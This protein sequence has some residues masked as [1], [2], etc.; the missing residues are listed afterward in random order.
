M[1]NDEKTTLVLTNN[2]NNHN[3]KRKWKLTIVIICILGVAV[4]GG[5]FGVKKI[6]SYNFFKQT[7]CYVP[8]YDNHGKLIN[9]SVPCSLA[10]DNVFTS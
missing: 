5:V 3:K 4:V 6:K 2:N 9:A 10:M 1:E 7:K 8:Q